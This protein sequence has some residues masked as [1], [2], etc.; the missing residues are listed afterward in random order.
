MLEN[1]EFAK[2]DTLNELYLDL[3][4]NILQSECRSVF[5]HYQELM[6]KTGVAEKE[7]NY[8][9]AHKL[10]SEAVELSMDN[11]KCRISDEVAW[12]QKIRLETLAEYQAMDEDLDHVEGKSIDEYLSDF[13]ALK[14]YYNRNK[15]LTQGVV[16]TPLF[17][18]AILQEDKGFLAGMLT[19]Y[20]YLDDYD[21]A[22]LLMR[23]MHE[24]GF[25]PALIIDAE[26]DL[27]RELAKRDVTKYPNEAPW[28]LLDNYSEKDKFYKAF[29]RSYKQ[30][31]LKASN[32]NIK[33]WP[34]IWKK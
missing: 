12:Y 28:D 33:Y 20:L 16:F 27:G 18:R 8:I 15:L 4:D 9:Q 10:A 24:P 3:K 5:D 17:D 26:E 30:E 29:R 34:F 32:W 22:L 21:H 19:H 1:Y 14:S 11:L 6:K 13:Q 31:W 25:D 23:R 2:G 7:G